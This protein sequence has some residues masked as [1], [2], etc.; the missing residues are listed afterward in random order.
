MVSSDDEVKLAVAP[1]GSSEK[2]CRGWEGV[3][4]FRS[5]C[6]DRPQENDWMT[7]VWMPYMGKTSHKLQC[8]LK[9]VNIEVRH[10]SSNKLHS[11]LH[12]RKDRKHKNTQPGVYKIPCE[13]G[14]VYIGK[15]GRSFNTRNKERKACQRLGTGKNQPSWN[16]HNNNT[17]STGKT[18]A[19]SHPF[20]T[21][22]PDE[23]EKPSRSY[24]TTQFHKIAGYTSTTSGTLSC[25][26]HKD[27]FTQV[28][29]Q[30]NIKSLHSRLQPT[31]KSSTLQSSS[32]SPEDGQH[33]LTEISRY[34]LNLNSS[35]QNYHMVLPQAA[36]HHLLFLLVID[37]LSALCT[38]QISIG[39]K[40]PSFRQV[41]GTL[42]C[43]LWCVFVCVCSRYMYSVIVNSWM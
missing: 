33:R 41:N 32:H 27:C 3:S 6:A 34:L 28:H 22:I 40:P 43:Y 30:L 18:A 35:F 8:I 36:P 31:H 12:T 16:T 21:G 14:K 25:R 17:R 11:S 19:S 15:T 5:V 9:T 4:I 26:K 23:F 13:C 38:P 37:K 7:G 10:R 24:N 1:C 42:Q 2:N 20:H 29:N 39:G